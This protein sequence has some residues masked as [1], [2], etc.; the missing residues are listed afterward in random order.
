[1]T[2]VGFS[3]GDTTPITRLHILGISINTKAVTTNAAVRAVCTGDSLKQFVML[4]VIAYGDGLLGTPSAGYFGGGLLRLQDAGQPI[5]Q[6]CVFYGVDGSRTN[7]LLVPAAV[8][9]EAVDTMGLVPH[10]IN[11]SCSYVGFPIYIESFNV[12][13][14]EGI[15]I[16]RCNGFCVFGIKVTAE[17]ADNPAYFPPQLNINN[18]QVEFFETGLDAENLAAVTMTNSTLLQHPD[19]TTTGVG[20]L[21]NN[22]KKANVTG[23]YVEARP[24]RTLDG[25]RPLGS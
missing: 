21:L 23:T 4:D 7:F 12:P 20:I 13:G 25:I 22:V 16:D 24:G 10:L 18:T 6:D 2:S 17:N 15:V 3:F 5:V 1:M 9:I 11:V 14:I 19:S 8:T